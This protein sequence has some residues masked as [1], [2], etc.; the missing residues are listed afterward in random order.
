MDI[1]YISLNRESIFI[2][3]D[4]KL[5]VLKLN[6]IKISVKEKLTAKELV[7]VLNLI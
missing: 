3:S 6:I 7:K 5:D 1:E 4:F 2:H